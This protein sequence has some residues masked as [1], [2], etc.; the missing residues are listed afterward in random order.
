[1]LAM[2]TRRTRLLGQHVQ[3]SR[4]EVGHDG[5]VEPSN[6]PFWLRIARDISA[7]ITAGQHEVGSRIPPVSEYVS[8]YA[9]ARGTV[10]KAVD[11]LQDR[12]VLE[13]HKGLG[14]YV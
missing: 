4:G 1:M 13:G 5:Q 8:Q 12:G 3:T 6:E 14:T 2:C 11:H 7:A 10:R 9:V